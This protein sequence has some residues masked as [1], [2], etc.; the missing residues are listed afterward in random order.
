MK[1]SGCTNV[2]LKKQEHVHLSNSL[3]VVVHV[4]SDKANVMDHSPADSPHTPLGS[5]LSTPETPP[6]SNSMA[7]REAQRIVQRLE[8]LTTTPL[9]DTRQITLVDFTLDSPE[10]KTS[11]TD[12]C[13]LFESP[14]HEALKKNDNSTEDCLAFAEEHLGAISLYT[15]TPLQTSPSAPT[16][17]TSFTLDNADA[18]HPKDTPAGEGNT[19]GPA[20]LVPGVLTSG[21][22]DTP[23]SPGLVTDGKEL[24]HF[25]AREDATAA[26]SPEGVLQ[27][28]P[29]S[30]TRNDAVHPQVSHRGADGRC[31]HIG[32][33]CPDDGILDSTSPLP[34]LGDSF[35]ITR[36]CPRAAARVAS[37]GLPIAETSFTI[38]AVPA[39]K[40]ATKQA[41]ATAPQATV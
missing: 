31:H 19:A 16:F 26:V 14:E 15:S 41:S 21:A 30:D 22:G 8:E 38:P 9:V 32:N 13:K 33:A 12:C 20:A 4:A 40:R 24:E 23:F 3:A 36:G 17:A 28:S 7:F 34:A 2:A 29:P 18:A 6:M 35:I 39:V 10:L 1:P 37:H 25:G 5:V 27:T 11:S